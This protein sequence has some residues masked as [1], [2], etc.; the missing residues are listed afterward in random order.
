MQGV[1]PEIYPSK[2]HPEKFIIPGIKSDQDLQQVLTELD[3]IG[4]LSE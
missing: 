1:T 3:K 2:V 4:Q